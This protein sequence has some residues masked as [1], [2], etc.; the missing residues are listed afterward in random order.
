MPI[1][2]LSWWSPLHAQL[3][4]GHAANSSQMW[5]VAR[6]KPTC[7]VHRFQVPPWLHGLLLPVCPFSSTWLCRSMFTAPGA[8]WGCHG[9]VHDAYLQGQPG[10][11]RPS[12]ARTK[13]IGREES[14][15]SWRKHLDRLD[16]GGWEY[17]RIEW[18]HQITCRLEISVLIMRLDMIGW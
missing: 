1:I 7:T 6:N 18:T 9:L 10:V 2:L 14:W 5:A 8:H 11:A 16:G 4:Q 3:V 13:N 12:K 15:R 17:W